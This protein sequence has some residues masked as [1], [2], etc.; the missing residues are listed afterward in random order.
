MKVNEDFL[1]T[2]CSSGNIE[3]SKQSQH[4]DN[5]ENAF[6][7]NNNN[8]YESHSLCFAI[9]FDYPLKPAVYDIRPR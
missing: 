2:K 3:Y 9:W 4:D 6:D 1:H 8:F 7:N 5:D